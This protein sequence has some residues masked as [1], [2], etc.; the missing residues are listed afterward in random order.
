MSKTDDK[1]NYYYQVQYK[2]NLGS[3]WHTAHTF[4]DLVT[5]LHDWEELRTNAELKIIRNF[6]WD[7]VERK[8]YLRLKQKYE[9]EK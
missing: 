1:D 7:E 5:L 9:R 3:S 2:S 8:E 6:G 4:D